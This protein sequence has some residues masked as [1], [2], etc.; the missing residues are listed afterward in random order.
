M[1]SFSHF[2]E[3]LLEDKE[4]QNLLNAIHAEINCDVAWKEH[5]T[6][7]IFHSGESIFGERVTTYPLKELMRLYNCHEVR[8]GF[9]RVG[10]F[11]VSVPSPLLNNDVF[12]NCVTAIR[13]FYGQK[14]AKDKLE[15]HYRNNFVQDLLYNRIS[16]QEELVNRAKMFNWHL[17]GG[18]V[19]LLIT[20]SS[21]ENAE[22]ADGVWSLILSR[23]RAFFPLSIFSHEN[24]SVVFLLSL[25]LKANDARHFYLKLTEVLKGLSKDLYERFTAKVLMAVGSYRDSPLLAYQSHQEARQALMIL[26]NVVRDKDFVFWDQLGGIR[27]IATLA[28][29]ES[30]RDF[31]RKTLAPLMQNGSKN[32][33]LMKTLLC[34]EE[35]NG[36]MR[37]VA[38]KLSLHYNTLKYRMLKIWELLEFDPKDSESH[39][40][41][42]LALRIYKLSSLKSAPKS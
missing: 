7:T 15:S 13:L 36:N 8:I 32:E 40:N 23:I 21:H 10:Y 24:Q 4:M 31:C 35:N 20:L 37:I 33:E 19:C 17:E 28:D 5:K 2:A 14:I 9:Q 1:K 39:F 27:L 25:N 16:H 22:E 34:L 42:S 29:T 38:Q 6:G 18:V 41:L 12:E 26:K 11:I 30:A 3:L